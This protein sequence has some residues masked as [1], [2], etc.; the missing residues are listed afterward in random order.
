MA[1][2]PITGKTIALIFTLLLS[3]I[4]FLTI[5]GGIVSLSVSSTETIVI[6]CSIVF[7]SVFASQSEAS[8]VLLNSVLVLVVIKSLVVLAFL[9]VDITVIIVIDSIVVLDVPKSV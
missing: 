9:E 2:P 1:T 6:L 3:S 7:L 5:I 4:F 8:V